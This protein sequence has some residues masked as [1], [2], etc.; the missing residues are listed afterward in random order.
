M[1]FLRCLCIV[2]RLIIGGDGED[3]GGDPFR[4]SFFEGLGR[5]AEGSAGGSYIVDQAK[6]PALE[7]DVRSKG[8]GPAEI[9]QPMAGRQ[10]GLWFRI[11]DAEQ[12]AIDGNVSLLGLEYASGC[13]SQEFRLVV[14][15][16]PPPPP[17]QRDGNNQI[18]ILQFRIAQKGGS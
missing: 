15:A 6:M 9:D 16:A 7:A 11:T 13:V 1:L 17:M 3:D 4:V 10:G 8:K 5:Y 14:A 18:H 12:I 2:G